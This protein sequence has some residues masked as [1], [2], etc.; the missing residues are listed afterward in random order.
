MIAWVLIL[1]EVTNGR[2]VSER[3]SVTLNAG[4]YTEIV[5]RGGR[6]G[7]GVLRLR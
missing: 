6:G 1:K 2:V 4:A 7:A 3:V 5:I